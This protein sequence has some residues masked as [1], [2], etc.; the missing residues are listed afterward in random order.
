MKSIIQILLGR[1]WGHS[2]K[3]HPKINIFA[4]SLSKS[5]SVNFHG[6]FKQKTFVSH[7]TK[8]GNLFG[9]KDESVNNKLK[10]SRFN[11]DIDWYFTY[12][13]KT[14]LHSQGSITRELVCV[15]KK[16]NH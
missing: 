4:L 12:N 15:T 14:I 8:K 5:H 9:E 3:S 11:G 13:K 7:F 10:G 6:D 16:A 1:I 2:Q